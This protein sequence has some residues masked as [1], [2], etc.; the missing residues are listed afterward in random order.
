MGPDAAI[1]L[2]WLFVL[3]LA[4]IGLFAGWIGHRHKFAEMAEAERKRRE[5]AEA[6]VRLLRKSTPRVAG[7]D[8]G[9]GGSAA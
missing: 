6:R 7:G 2:C 9:T 3:T 1:V 4:V 8:G 5:L